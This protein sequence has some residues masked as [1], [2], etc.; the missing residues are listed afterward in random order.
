MHKEETD[1]TTIIV[2]W[3]ST[4]RIFTVLRAEG[5]FFS[6][7]CHSDIF[8][9]CRNVGQNVR[10]CKTRIWTQLPKPF[11]LTPVSAR[12]C[13][14]N[15]CIM[16]VPSWR[17]IP[18]FIGCVFKPLWCSFSGPV[19]LHSGSHTGQAVE[20]LTC[21]QSGQDVSVKGLRTA[22]HS[23]SDTSLCVCLWRLSVPIILDV[24]SLHFS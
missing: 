20:H 2:L 12:I 17:R 1:E 9:Y 21:R 14:C 4:R 13:T 23:M 19:G 15:N 24:C 8:N 5:F 11:A 18:P 16:S 10:K 22:L 3:L 7:S 6:E